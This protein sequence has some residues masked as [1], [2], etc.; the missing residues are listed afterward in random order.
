MWKIVNCEMCFHIFV[1]IFPTT[2][3]GKEAEFLKSKSIIAL[4]CLVR[5]WW[6]QT[7]IIDYTFIHQL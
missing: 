2:P 4:N 3:T 7:K 5:N 1:E 6:N